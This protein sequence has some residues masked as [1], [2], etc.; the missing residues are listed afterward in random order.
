MGNVSSRG[1]VVCCFLSY[2]LSKYHTTERNRFNASSVLKYMNGNMKNLDR[3][4]FQNSYEQ[5]LIT[6]SDDVW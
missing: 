1:K 2:F 5:E 4:R 6:G 3:L